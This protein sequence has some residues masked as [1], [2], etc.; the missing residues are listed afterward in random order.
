MD[1]KQRQVPNMKIHGGVYLDE[2]SHKGLRSVDVE[3]DT[4]AYRT[5]GCILQSLHGS[6]NCAFNKQNRNLQY[7]GK[8]HADIQ[9]FSHVSVI[10]TRSRLFSMTK[11][12]TSSIFGPNDIVFVSSNFGA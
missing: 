7:E 4:D 2:C 12:L 6:L 9:S 3:D 1:G 11:Q 8:C 10:Q 5:S